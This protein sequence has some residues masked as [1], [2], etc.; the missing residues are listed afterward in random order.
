MVRLIQNSLRKEITCGC[1]NSAKIEVASP[2]YCFS[3][4]PVT[5]R[6][7]SLARE[8]EALESKKSPPNTAS[9]LPNA[10]FTEGT[11]LLVAACIKGTFEK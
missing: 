6:F 2:F 9:L 1:L 10:W 7:L 5:S 8:I 11:P 3:Y 4:T